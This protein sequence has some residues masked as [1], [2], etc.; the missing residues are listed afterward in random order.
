VGRVYCAT[1]PDVDAARECTR[2]EALHCPACVRW[3][4]NERKPVAA[5]TRCDGVLRPLNVRVVAPARAEAS[6][7]LRRLFTPTGL[8]TVGAVALVT[9]M[10]DVPVPLVGLLI[11]VV[12]QLGLAGTYFSLVDHVGSGKVGFPAPVEADG[13]PFSTL[14]VR[15]MLCLLI[16]C[17]P[18]G[19]WLGLAGATDDVG[20]LVAARPFTAVVLGLVTVAWLTAGLL[21]MLVTV[22]GLA[23]FW[24]PALVRAAALDWPGYLRLSG[25][26]VGSTLGIALVRLVLARLLGHVPFLSTL[27][28]TAATALALF[29]QATL[30]GAFVHRHREIYTTR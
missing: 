21:A 7:S 19:M 9:A 2:C 8:V 5:C 18:F 20:A 11:G 23:A 15:G 1:H 26:M 10:S 13:W 3:V 12:G 29:A 24:P 14:V 16:V 25:M 4:G 6:A 17:T 30:V 22:S 28:L 27:V